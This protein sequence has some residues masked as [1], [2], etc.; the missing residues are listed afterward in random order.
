MNF[1]FVLRTLA[2]VA[3]TCAFASLAQA[4]ATR[5]WVS[6]V[7]DDANPCSRTAPCKTFAG[8]I[9]KTA[10]GGE[11]D[12]LDPGGFG[13]V[14]ITKA[15]TIDGS[16]TF[17][18]IL[19]S[20]TTGIF[21]NAPAGAFVT[22]RGLSIQGA[23][24][25]VSP[26]VTGIKYNSGAGLNVIDCIIFNQNSQGIDATLS[27][28]GLLYVEHTVIKNCAGDGL[29]ATTTSGQV[30]VA[31]KNS[32]FT[33]CGV[34]LHAKGNSRVTA[35]GCTFSNNTGDGVFADGTTGVGVANVSNSSLLNN[36]GAGVHAAT[37]GAVARINNCDII[38]NSGNG[39]LVG[40]SGEVDTWGN[41]RFVG[42]ADGAVCTSCTGSTPH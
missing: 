6:G 31:I 40:A 23:R 41:N 37:G 2:L 14:N 27:A 22:I 5:T 11:I 35:D 4:Q 18:S 10:T 3:F 16:G 39:A 36:G 25:G 17:S 12:T 8:A 13:T 26:G 19:N 28:S 9:S 38:Q 20:G 30:K 34:G 1:R 15:M 21:V 7:G 29:S 24:Q 32:S 42:N 33:E